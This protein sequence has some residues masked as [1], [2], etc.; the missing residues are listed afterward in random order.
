MTPSIKLNTSYL[1][2]VLTMTI[3]RQTKKILDLENTGNIMSK[4]PT[5][6]VLTVPFK[7][8]QASDAYL[9]SLGMFFVCP[10][11]INNRLPSEPLLPGFSTRPE[12][13]VL[14]CSLWVV[15]HG[16]Y[17]STHVS[18]FYNFVEITRVCF[19]NFY[20]RTISNLHVFIFRH[21]K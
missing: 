8:C 20:W 1:S 13:V 2:D 17:C 4:L 16:H 3:F 15:C 9:F 11:V 6:V 18:A 10:F 21:I 19:Y 7:V 12:V 14:L 5:H